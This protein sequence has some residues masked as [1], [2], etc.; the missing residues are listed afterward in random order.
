MRPIL[1]LGLITVKTPAQLDTLS[2][3]T[4]IFGAIVGA[5]FLMIAS[6]ISIAI[7][8]E[9]GAYPKDPGKRRMWF[10]ILMALSF[11]TFF[12]YNMSMVALTVAPNLHSKFMMTNIIGSSISFVT[13][14]ILGFIM[15][16][17]FST[18]KLGN[19]FPSKK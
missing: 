14:F 3:Q 16:K 12:L 2:I 15:S 19:W 9:G 18:G 17:S 11:S 6:L 13:Y 7:K 5:C 10:W 8:F 1:F 4:Y